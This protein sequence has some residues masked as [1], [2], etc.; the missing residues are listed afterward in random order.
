M[1]A[2]VVAI[3]A[4]FE[5]FMAWSIATRCSPVGISSR[6]MSSLQNPAIEHLLHVGSPQA[7]HRD[8]NRAEMGCLHVVHTIFAVSLSM[9]SVFIDSL[10]ILEHSTFEFIH[11]FSIIF[12]W[13]SPLDALVGV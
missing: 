3:D 13:I 1:A 2:T 11:F 10:S 5:C 7:M 4:C 8:A 6:V 12:I 9:L